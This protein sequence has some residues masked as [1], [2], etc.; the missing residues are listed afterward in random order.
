MAFVDGVANPVKV[1]E[2]CE[3]CSA[4]VQTRATEHEW[5]VL[6]AYP[7]P[8]GDWV[9][10]H[11]FTATRATAPVAGGYREHACSAPQNGAERAEAS[12]EGSY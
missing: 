12:H 7:H 4:Y 3:H 6:D 8:D 2:R 1:A 9:I 11:D 10:R 5:I